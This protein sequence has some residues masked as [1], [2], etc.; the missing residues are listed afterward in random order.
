MQGYVA[1]QEHTDKIKTFVD[2]TADI[3]RKKLDSQ[4]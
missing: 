4:D 1:Q 3:I 2:Q